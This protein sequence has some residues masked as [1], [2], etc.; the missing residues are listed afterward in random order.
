MTAL[1]IRTNRLVAMFGVLLG[2]TLVSCFDHQDPTTG[3]ESITASAVDP[4]LSLSRGDPIGWDDLEIDWPDENALRYPDDASLIDAVR[5]TGGRVFIGFKEGS[6]AKIANR[7]ALTR[8]N[9]RKTKVRHAV[10]AGTIMSGRNFVKSMG[11]TVIIPFRH[12]PS[13]VAEIDPEI[14]PTILAHPLVDYIEPD[15]YLSISG[16]EDHSSTVPSS[17]TVAF[18]GGQQVGWSVDSIHARDAHALGYTGSGEGIT[19]ID[20]GVLTHEDLPPLRMCVRTDPDGPGG[21]ADTNIS[22]EGPWHGT[23]VAGVALMRD[24]TIGWLGV[25]PGAVMNA[26]RVC[27]DNGNC[28]TSALVDAFEIVAF[29]QVTDVVNVSL[30]TN[31]SNTDLATAVAQAWNHGDLLV[32]AAGNTPG[33]SVQY[34]AKYSQVI[35][36]S[37]L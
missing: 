21:C 25:A 18:Q 22:P 8:S 24:N 7:P 5:Q 28:P 3:P 32:A 17:G 30:G 35:A 6:V 4:Y 10:S 33:S 13:V 15:M 9:G 12:L 19:V 29:D 16:G 34:P 31:N 14:A 27:D 37:A 20:R 36:V 11:A 26:I 23:R 2:V 1:T